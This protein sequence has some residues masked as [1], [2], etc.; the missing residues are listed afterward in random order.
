MRSWCGRS[1]GT[2]LP[3]KNGAPTGFNP[4]QLPPTPANV[5]FLKI[6]LRSL[7]RGGA[8]LSVREEGDLDHALRGTL[9]LEPRCAPPLAAHRVHRCHAQRRR[10]RAALALVCE[11]AR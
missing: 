3:L 4:L 7:V 10:S 6:W 1:G 2:Y 5:E 11:L 8:P 9:A